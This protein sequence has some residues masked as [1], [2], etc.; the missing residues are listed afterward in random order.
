M[1]MQNVKHPKHHEVYADNHTA[2]YNVLKHG[3]QADHDSPPLS[4][5]QPQAVLWGKVIVWM[6]Y[7]YHLTITILFVFIFFF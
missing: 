1:V 3:H 7:F 2:H 5:C 6:I 4:S